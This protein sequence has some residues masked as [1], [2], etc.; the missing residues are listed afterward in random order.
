[1]YSSI[2]TSGFTWRR[3]RIWSGAGELSYDSR[4]SFLK[5]PSHATRRCCKTNDEVLEI[6]SKI[7]SLKRNQAAQDDALDRPFNLPSDE[8][9][10]E[11][12]QPQDGTLNETQI[13]LAMDR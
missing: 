6:K 5:K 9:F 13:I 10:V 3:I 2:R 7:A 11:T 12:Y 4:T 1:M 8:T